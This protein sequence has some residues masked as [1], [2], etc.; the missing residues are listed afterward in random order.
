MDELVNVLQLVVIKLDHISSQLGDMS[1]TLESIDDK[2]GVG[3]GLYG[4]DD[5]CS[6]LDLIESSLGLIDSSLGSID[7]NISLL[8][9]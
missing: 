9:D 8:G 6:R 7:T 4:I 3:G 5:V 2:L 1:Q